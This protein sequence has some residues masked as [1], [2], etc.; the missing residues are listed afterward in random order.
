MRSGRPEVHHLIV[1]A[2]VGQSFNKVEWVDDMASR[3]GEDGKGG[4]SE[5]C[6]GILPPRLEFSKFRDALSQSW[7][8]ARH[9]AFFIKL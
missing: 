9:Q 2:R 6:L 5:W 4:V 3:D 7:L 8:A 1:G